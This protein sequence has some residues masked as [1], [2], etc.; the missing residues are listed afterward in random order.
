MRH[1]FLKLQSK[2]LFSIFI[3]FYSLNSLGY[4]SKDIIFNKA[5]YNRW[6]RPQLNNIRNDYSTL[7]VL[8]NPDLK[9]VKPIFGNFIFIKTHQKKFIRN[10]S[11]KKNK[12]CLELIIRYL[13]SI[14]KSLVLLDSQSFDNEYYVMQPNEMLRAFGQFI[15]FKQDLLD[16]YMEFFNFHFYYQSDMNSHLSAKNLVSRLSQ[17]Y[18]YFNVY[19]IS[20]LDKA[21]SLSFLELWNGYIKPINTLLVFESDYTVFLRQLNQLNL[22]WNNFNVDLTKRNVKLSK[23]ILSLLNTMHSRWNSILKVTLR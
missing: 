17:S 12:Q 4:T 19:I 13:E 8:V 23:P 20:T 21:Y 2:A 3:C 22:R 5:E 16:I 18:N 7:L 6:V 14:E 10:C 11:E 1:Y 9:K 15:K